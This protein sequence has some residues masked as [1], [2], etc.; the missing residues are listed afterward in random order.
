MYMRPTSI[1]R[2]SPAHLLPLASGLALLPVTGHA[3]GASPLSMPIELSLSSYLIIA[4]LLVL[5]ITMFF[6]FRRRFQATS[7]E[8]QAITSE[9]ETTRQRLTDTGKS[10]ELSQQELKDTATRYQGILYD[11]RVGMFQLDGEGSCTYLNSALQEMSGLYPKKALKEGLASAIHPADREAFKLAWQAFAGGG[12]NFAMRFRLVPAKGREVH[13][14]CRATKVFDASKEVESYIGWVSDLSGIQSE[15]AAQEAA[16]TRYQHFVGETI[17]GFYQLSSATPIPLSANPAKMAEAILGKMALADCNE[18]FAAVYGIPRTE[19]IGKTIGELHGGCGPFRNAETLQAFA[20]AGFKSID[21]ESVRQDATGT[22]INLLNNVIGIIEENKLVA[23]WGSQRNISYQKREVASQKSQLEFLNTILAS[24]P[25]DIHVKDSRCRYLYVSQR[26]AERTG[27]PQEAW[28]GKTI[29]EVMPATPREHDKLAIEAMKSGKLRRSERPFEA[30]GRTGWM[31]NLLSPII[32]SEGLVE[33]VVGLSL[34]ISEQKN[35]EELALQACQQLE[36]KLKLRTEELHKSQHENHERAVA[37]T[38]SIEKLKIAEA[39]LTVREREYKQ[40]L[41]ARK[42]TEEALRQSE[43]RLAVRQRELEDQLAGRIAE[44]AAETDKRQKWEEL[45]SI[46]EEELCKAEEHASALREQFG[47]ETAL[48]REAEKNLAEAKAALEKY[49][50]GLD[51]ATEEHAQRLSALT[52]EHETAFAG[53]HEGR[54]AAELKLRKTEQLLLKIQ[55]EL[56]RTAEQHATELENEV[57]A[58]KASAEKLVRSLEELDALRQQFAERIEAETKEIKQELA[59][60]QIREKALHQHEKDMEIRIKELET[61]LQTKVREFDAQIQAREGAEVQKQQIEQKL[62]QMNRRQQDLI[63]R[64]T[65]KLNLSIAEIRLAEVKQRKQVGDMQQAKESL[66]DALRERTAELERIR[67]ECRALETALGEANGSLKRLADQQERRIGKETN[68]LRDQL[69]TLQRSE[70]M[71]RFKLESFQQEKQTLEQSLQE[72]EEEVAKFKAEYRKLAEAYKSN[73]ARIKQQAEEQDA[74]LAR[75]TGELQRKIDQ[76]AKG[77]RELEAKEKDLQE[78]IAHQQ[79]SIN[80]LLDNLNAETTRREEAEGKLKELQL[81]FDAS[82]QNTEALVGEQTRSLAMDIAQSKRNAEKLT[83]RLE[84]AEQSLVQRDAELSALRQE[85]SEAA[86]VIDSH[87]RQIEELGRKH[88]AELEQRL[89][90]VKEINRINSNLIDELKDSVQETIN[91]VIKSALILGKSDNL[92]PEQKQDLSLAHSRCRSLI[93]MMNHRSEYTHLADAAEEL[94]PAECDLHGLIAAIDRQFSHYAEA[95]KLFFAISFAQYQSA[96]N[97]PKLVETDERKVQR[98][99]TILLGY[100]IDKTEKGRLGLHATRKA[101]SEEMANVAFEL[102]YTAKQSNDPLL[103][104]VLGGKE[105]REVVDM[106]FGLTLARR[107]IEMLQG[108]SSVE[109]RTGGITAITVEFPFRK[110][111][112]TAAQAVGEEKKAGA[113]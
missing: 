94:E 109:F 12:E 111:A 91:P 72:R 55:E 78:R 9:L 11:A 107:Y 41:D 16:T 10:L 31:E 63:D 53:E 14:D 102:A 67:Q 46:K 32:S 17:E 82:Q 85:Q 1:P 89:E 77:G 49:K 73:S 19:L 88:R 25:A 3:Q 5:G 97:V 21:L 98:I 87:A 2:L 81:A 108:K 18:T 34:D 90:A 103:A 80:K 28:I 45:L 51:A 95:K 74:F 104:S 20:E 15:K 26:L 40:H 86:R 112:N 39:E 7:R 54:A 58:R 99:L 76:L 6:L 100:A 52:Q 4:V 113:A 23:I 106:K 57:A 27:I 36:S 43:E 47:K 105:G 69:E 48:H 50:T 92:L 83:R 84:S 42:Q 29:F 22:R 96:N 65:H 68:E 110:V 64:E 24:L 75:H 8:L 61:A 59:R 37:L 33:G 60:K 35:K 13:V 66:E 62:A 56:K 79:D 30:R 70:E 93:D 38:T 101:S 44:L 71:L